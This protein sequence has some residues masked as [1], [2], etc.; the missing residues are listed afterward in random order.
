MS[1]VHMNLTLMHSFSSSFILAWACL[2]KLELSSPV[3]VNSSCCQTPSSS[4]RLFF[5]G[6]SEVQITNQQIP[7]SRAPRSWIVGSR[8]PIVW[9]MLHIVFISTHAPWSSRNCWFT[10]TMLWNLG[11]RVTTVPRPKI[12]PTAYLLPRNAPW[13]ATS[14]PAL[15]NF[16]TIA[17]GLDRVV[18]R[19]VFAWRIA[20]AA[21]LGWL[22][23]SGSLVW[24]E[25]LGV[26]IAPNA[27]TRWTIRFS[28]ENERVSII[29]R[30][31]EFGQTTKIR[32]EMGKRPRR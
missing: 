6:S 32:I 30:R 27:V 18:E 22:W 5:C 1:L 15:H 4:E 12:H 25:R 16:I 8:F 20:T 14:L 26:A 13:P 2:R 19:L 9:I 31:K 21:W 10:E 11:G 3:A 24:Y 23:W 17:S 29:Q 7:W 28:S